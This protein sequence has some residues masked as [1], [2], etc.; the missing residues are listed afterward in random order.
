MLKFVMETCFLSLIKLFMKVLQIR[1]FVNMLLLWM[2][3]FTKF[4]VC[5]D[6]AKIYVGI[7]THHFLQIYNKNMAL[8]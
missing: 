3:F 6:I 1:A 4:F 2:L 8:D 7:D 5:I